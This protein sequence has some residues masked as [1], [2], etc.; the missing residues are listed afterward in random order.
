MGFAPALPLVM[1]CAAIY[2]LGFGMFD[3]NNMPILCQ[4][5]PPVSAPPATA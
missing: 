3:A 5:A 1:I 2:G 4:L